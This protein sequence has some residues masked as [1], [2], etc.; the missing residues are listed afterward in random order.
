MK[1]H[2]FFVIAGAFLLSHAAEAAKMSYADAMLMA[3]SVIE[4]HQSDYRCA[5]MTLDYDNGN[6]YIINADGGGWAVIAADDRFPQ[7]VLA[8]SPTGSFD[9]ETAPEQAVMLLKN[10]ACEVEKLD[11][12]KSR[13]VVRRTPG[14]SVAPLLGETEWAQ[15]A[16]FNRM[17]PVIDGYRCPTGCVNTAQAQI[18]YY[19]QYPKVGRGSHTYTVDSL[20]LSADFSE[21]TY[22]WDL[23]KPVYYDNESEEA[24]DAVALLMRDCGIANSSVYHPG[25]TGAEFNTEGIV[26]YF[27]YDKSIKYLGSTKCSRDY[28][29]ETIREDLDAGHPV[30][31][32]GGGPEGA[33][34][35]VCDGYD[36]NG[37]FHFNFGWGPGSSGYYLTTATGFDSAPSVYYSIMPDAGNPAAITASSSDDFVWERGDSIICNISYYIACKEHSTVDVALEVYNKES[38]E[39]T[40][41]IKETLSNVYSRGVAE[42]VFDDEIADGNYRLRPVFRANGREWVHASFAEL[43]MTYVD[44]TVSNGI[45]TYT[46][47]VVDSDIDPGV[48]L[49]DGVYYR[50]EDG[51]AIVTKRNVRGNSYS[52]NVVIP[53]TISYQNSTIPVEEIGDCAFEECKVD[54]LVIG[55]N[56]KIIGFGA[57]GFAK[58]GNLEFDLPS[59]LEIIAGWGFNA[60]EL[61]IIEL[62]EG[63]KTIRNA[64]FQSSTLSKIYLPESLQ[65]IESAPFNS[66]RNLKDIYVKWTDAD[67]LPELYENAFNG[68]EQSQITLHVP[69][70]CSKIYEE[71]ALWCNFNIVDGECS[72][73]ADIVSPDISIKVVDG[74]II[75]G[76]VDAVVYNLSGSVVAESCKGVVNGLSRGVY[77]VRAG[78]KVV[79]VVI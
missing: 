70:G 22:R 28:F 74:S 65:L 26:Q 2:S 20:T 43:C 34:A 61:D 33:H 30:L 36:E 48:V 40:Y 6:Y 75:I 46:N 52:G 5:S 50:M 59:N 45:K 37:Y 76:D 38:E 17:C 14:R 21:S 9:I 16:P 35:F 24:K 23:M 60:C 73:V 71:A 29:E 78:S 55:S 58:I 66:S 47:E 67:L 62:P 49:I 41:T 3:Q 15:T 42:F 4:R 68:I 32:T 10:Y 51:K 8:Y 7:A 13:M 56:L 64:A 1:L 11:Q 77:I 54:S 27:G 69:D 72:S 31:Y 19:Y 39:T 12:S 18:M 63:L 79:K 44:V 57:F 53:A 25:E